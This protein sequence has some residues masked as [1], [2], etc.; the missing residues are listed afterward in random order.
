MSTSSGST[1][2]KVTVAFMVLALIA[3]AWV[4][5]MPCAKSDLS[6]YYPLEIGSTWSY[7]TTQQGKII[8]GPDSSEGTKIGTVEQSAVGVSRLSSDELQIVEVS[9]TVEDPGAVTDSTVTVESV[10]HV[11]ATSSAI[12]LHA[13]DS[14]NPNA[15]SMT[16]PVVL[17]ADPPSTET[18]TNQRG[19]VR[20][21]FTV[22]SQ[23]VEPVTVPAGEFPN[24]L[25]KVAE[26]PV[27]GVVSG[28]QIRSGS[29]KESTWFVHDVGIVKQVRT[30]AYTVESPDDG[31]ITFE[32]TLERVLTKFSS[33]TPD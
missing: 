18:T 28:L 4:L 20:I 10:L 30:L 11:S 21:S 1:A 32:E 31:E 6:S 29:M 16:D 22:I 8:G 24:A 7:K 9:Q 33:A 12:T 3:V 15:P 23:D 5:A 25:K 14:E 19:S 17:L 2:T 27:T 26:G 13:V